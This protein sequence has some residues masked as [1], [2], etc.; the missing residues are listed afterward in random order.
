MINIKQLSLFLIAA[1]IFTL[2]CRKNQIQDKDLRDFNQ[3]NLVANAA[4]YNPVTVDPTLMNA[5]GLAWS[6]G[7]IAWVNSMSGHVSELYTGEGAIVRAP[8]LIPSPADTMG[9]SPT[10][11]VFNSTKG[12]KLPNGA[13]AAFIFVGEDGVLSAWNG[14]AG[15]KAFRI[16][17]HSATS[18]YTGLTLAA[19]GAAKNIYAANFKTG[20]IDVWDTT[21]T[22]VPMQFRDPSLP[23]GYA[24]FNIQSVG[25]WLFVMYAKVGPEGDEE[26]GAGNGFVDIFNTD[27]SF[28]KRFASRGKLNAPWGV[29]QA[30]ASFLDDNDMDDDDNG[31]D[32]S[33]H[34][35]NNSGPGNNGHN[36]FGDNHHNTDPVIL[37]GNFGD[38]HINAYTLDGKFLG[39]LQSHK[40]T[41]VINGLWA[42]SFAPSTA[43]AIDPNRLYFTAGPNDEADGLFGYLIKK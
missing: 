14:P 29:V 40:R 27:G 13:A 25:S 21:W 23:A 41:I 1:L 17:D 18:S 22:A 38:G 5:W 4:W 36:V 32:H 11:I 28:V 34:N 33:G 37:V 39:Q 35:S 26:K 8:V 43:T 7:G 42:L 24:P 30:A 6:P 19:N 20:K 12:F 10:G 31:E 2:G 3:V 9:G 15:N 16:A